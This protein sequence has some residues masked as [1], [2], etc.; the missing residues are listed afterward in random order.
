MLQPGSVHLTSETTG[1]T[2]FSMTLANMSNV[3]VCPR[4]TD[5]AANSGLTT[6]FTSDWYST[7][8]R[9]YS[10]FVLPSSL[11]LDRNTTE[12]ACWPGRGVTPNL[13]VSVVCPPGAR[14]VALNSA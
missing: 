12:C 3:V 10:D 13:I 8:H 5:T 7:P 2:P 11:Q 14:F 1:S 9:P 6:T 4:R